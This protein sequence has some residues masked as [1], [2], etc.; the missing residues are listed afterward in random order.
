[1]WSIQVANFTKYKNSLTINGLNS[2]SAKFQSIYMDLSHLLISQYI[3]CIGYY[4]V[5]SAY[6]YAFSFLH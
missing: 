6:K 3:L 2:A 1:M 4:Y 5:F